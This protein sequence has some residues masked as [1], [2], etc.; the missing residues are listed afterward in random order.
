MKILKRI[1]F[2]VLF[3][4]GFV[5]W[6]MAALSSV[7]AEFKL[8]STEGR[9]E[10]S[11]D[12]KN[13]SKVT[14]PANIKS[15]T[16]IKTGPSGS[17]TLVLPDKTQTRIAK[18]SELLLKGSKKKAGEVKLNLGK[19]WAK[20]NKKPVKIKIKAPNAVA[21]IRGTEWV[22][23]VKNNGQSSLAVMEGNISLTSNAGETQAIEGGS[24]A[25]VTKSGKISVAKLVNPGEYLQFVYRYQVEPLAYLPQNLITSDPNGRII[26]ALGSGA[27]DLTGSEKILANKLKVGEF[28][29]NF[30]GAPKEISTLT[31]YANRKQYLSIIYFAEP[32][33]W[34]TS[35]KGWLNALKAE[36]YLAIGNDSQ[37]TKHINR[38]NDNFA[39][40]YIK[41]KQFIAKGL[42]DDAKKAIYN[43]VDEETASASVFYTAGQIEEAIGNIELSK[44]NYLRS[45]ALANH[46]HLPAL[47]LA[48]VALLQGNY[49]QA[50]KYI[51]EA[52]N[53][54]ASSTSISSSYAEY[55]SLRNN[56]D[57]ATEALSVL[58]NARK[59]D[60]QM[61]TAKGII[62]LKKGESEK[63]RDTFIEA[64]ALERN[65]SRAY[66]FMAVSHLHS[67]EP[68]IAFRQLNLAS[69]LD[70]NDPLPHVIAS[71]IYASMLKPEEAAREAGLAR[72]KTDGERSFGQLANDQQGG[73][74]VGRR[75][76]EVGLPHHAREASIETRKSAWAGSYLFDAATARSSLERNS[77]YVM[78]FTLDSQTFGSRRDVPDVVSRPGQYG[79]T[80]YSGKVGS[81]D[82]LDLQFKYGE[83]GRSIEGTSER[84]YLYDLGLYG[85]QRDAYHASDGS[86]TSLAALGFFG[87]GWRD[88]YDHNRFITANI[89]PF[90]TDG[91]F[92]VN[93][94]TMRIDYGDSMRSD[95]RTRIF[96]LAGELGDADVKLKVSTG[97]TGDDSQ[98]TNKLEFGYAEIGR[99]TQLGQIDWSIEGTYANAD[100]DYTVTHPSAASCTDIVSQTYQ[101]RTETISSTEY[102]ILATVNL[103]QKIDDNLFHIRLKGYNNFHDFDQTRVL[104][105]V[106]QTPF[107]SDRDV[108]ELVGS[109]GYSGKFG[110]TSIRLG[111]ISEY[112]P[113][114]QVSL[115]ANDVSGI[116]PKYEFMKPGGE[117]EQVS[118]RLATNLGAGIRTFV[119]YDEFTVHNNPIY[120]IMREQW[121]AD[122]LENFT[123]DRY[124]NPNIEELFSINN[125]FGAAEF[126][127]HSLALEKTFSNSFSFSTGY[128]KWE[129]TTV[130]HPNIS[131][132][133]AG[134]RVSGV[135]ETSM[136][137][138]FTA[139]LS[140][141]SILSARYVSN[142]SIFDST[143]SSTTDTQTYAV[144]YGISLESSASQL[145]IG[146]NGDLGGSSDSHTLSVG[147]R[148]YF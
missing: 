147:Y 30:V 89:V 95:A 112:H 40:T 78:G 8:L 69:E 126:T 132:D 4:L 5:F 13:W 100:S 130:D 65:Y 50:K 104:D 3:V 11:S 22:V 56:L 46:W 82:L 105:G 12:Q 116:S 31:R 44:E 84:S 118:A 6:M 20:T 144:S 90:Q 77:K 14:G 107:S 83:N 98:Q 136:Y 87:Y 41:A 28:P 111:Y 134:Q 135:P 27:E 7:A 24:V 2:L 133:V 113:T 74:N 131:D 60:F 1:N 119:E 122:L 33:N 123:L 76:L 70:P 125:N 73:A 47:S 128:E 36:S 96:R 42:L 88:N 146:L 25:A 81:N 19:I 110:N 37:A 93:D 63:A 35:W 101:N 99:N 137:I 21:S 103:K 18:N 85:A 55:Y 62:E 32:Q 23:E 102:D 114:G 140:D 38:I 67:G 80:E 48:S 43:L 139:S 91:T 94:T 142:T 59:A 109:F 129:T 54:D 127:K 49:D 17:A 138:G 121:N 10:I 66:S 79:Y 45:Y 53:R 39:K 115:S 75:F 34:S 141:N 108:N 143:T 71:Q 145:S 51:E 16:W 58:I 15:G 97:C 9:V 61:L 148:H 92:P 52:K 117:I 57:A 72:D 106:T 68:D 120:L 64:T 26:R 29:S 124:E 86:D